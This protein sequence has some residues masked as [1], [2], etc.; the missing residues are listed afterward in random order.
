[1]GPLCVEHDLP[2]ERVFVR[3]RPF[4]R[5]PAFAEWRFTTTGATFAPMLRTASERVVAAR[6]PR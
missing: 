4:T 5:R 2:V 3:G 1:M 6:S